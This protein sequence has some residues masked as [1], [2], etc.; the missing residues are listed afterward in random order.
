MPQFLEFNL[1]EPII[2]I[3][4]LKKIVKD[5]KTKNPNLENYRL[6]DVGFTPNPSRD[7]SQIKLYFIK[8][9]H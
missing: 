3:N 6:M 4:E 2:L 1:H 7:I 5:L 9:S 8:K